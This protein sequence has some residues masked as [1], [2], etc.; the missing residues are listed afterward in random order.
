[1]RADPGLLERIVADPPPAFALLHRPVSTGGRVEVLTGTMSMPK[2]LAELPV[3]EPAGGGGA[4]HDLLAVLPYRQVVERGFDCHDDGEPLLAMSI[5][6]QEKRSV[7]DVERL[8]VDLPIEV[9]DGGFDIDDQHYA[10]VVREVLDGEIAAGEGANFVIARSWTAEVPGLGPAQALAVFRRLLRMERGA[11]WTFVAC[12]DGRILLGATPER[13]VSVFDG[14]ATLNPISGT[15]RYG[16]GRPDEAAVLAF[17]ADGKESGELHM[18]L[19]EELK[20]MAR[21][22]PEGGQVSGPFL[23]EMASLAHTEYLI[24]G[25]TRADV[26]EVLRQTMFAPTV[27]GSP[28]ENA[29]RV[30]ARHEPHGRGYYS[31]VIALV[32]HDATGGHSLDSAI[33]I[34]TA[35]VRQ[36]RLRIGVGATLVRD[37]ECETEVA[38]T[39]AKTRGLRSVLERGSS[40]RPPDPLPALVDRPGVRQALATRN[41]FLAP[42]WFG[43]RPSGAHSGLAGRTVR[44]VDAEDSFT[45]ML[46]AQLRALGMVVRA[47]E[48][49][50]E[51]ALHD[52]DLLVLGPGPGDPRQ[53][54]E[55]RIARL[56]RLAAAAVAARRPLLAVCLS[57]QVLG[58]VLGLEVVRLPRSNQG[59]ARRVPWFGRDITVGFYNSYAL[60]CELPVIRLADGQPVEVCREPG[61]AEV[62]GLRGPSFRSVQFHPE[63]VLSIDGFGMLGELVADLVRTPVPVGAR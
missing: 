31:G 27:V 2:S 1:M 59:V 7:A 26:R 33:L 38:E 17:L 62:H 20:M 47:G 21:L 48:A 25:R 45:A 60:R 15:L 58:S 49:T 24:R 5:L 54:T 23:K 32:S 28:L 63:S 10:A 42:F 16:A 39:A 41:D 37:S 19:D 9:R 43:D 8:I 11:Y 34:R 53:L 40:P 13:H 29:A 18:V 30:I 12:F 36:G 4:G 57:H 61:S 55:P 56:H 22:C 50:D 52:S 3:T 46:E 14:T 35:D 6:E 51:A 44:V